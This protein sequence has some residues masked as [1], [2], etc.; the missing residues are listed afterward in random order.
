MVR[1]LVREG[2]VVSVESVFTP[3]SA[4]SICVHGDSPVPSRWQSKCRL[5]WS[6][7]VSKLRLFARENSNEHY[8]PATPQALEEAAQARL[9][10]RKRLRQT[11]RRDSA[12]H[13]PSEYDSPATRL[14][15]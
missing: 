15:I 4:Q 10:I 2:G 1:Q 14:G 13:D 9:R 11:H 5:H 8:Y 3:I 12:G 6:R 7:K